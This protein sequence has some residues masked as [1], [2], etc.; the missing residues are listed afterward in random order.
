MWCKDDKK[1]AGDGVLNAAAGAVD[2]MDGPRSEGGGGGEEGRGGR[3]GGGGGVD[4][5]ALKNARALNG[6]APYSGAAIEKT[7]Y[8]S[9]QRLRLKPQPLTGVYY[10][11]KSST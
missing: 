3:V 10:Y 2:G 8:R 6:R 7:P 9:S 11:L 1:G 4:D 5:A